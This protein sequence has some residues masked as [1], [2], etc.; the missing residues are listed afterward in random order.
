MHYLKLLSFS[1]VSLTLIGGGC[2]L[3]FKLYEST[4]TLSQDDA[5]FLSE[6]MFDRF[7]NDPQALADD[8]TVDRYMEGGEEIIS[9]ESVQEIRS[10]LNLEDVHSIEVTYIQNGIEKEKDRLNDSFSYAEGT[11][12]CGS[13]EQTFFSIDTLWDSLE[14]RWRIVYMNADICQ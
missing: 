4:S 8:M 14:E 6:Q 13:N 10:V 12:I 7:I 3:D 11:Y 5:M 9:L 1:L 2:N